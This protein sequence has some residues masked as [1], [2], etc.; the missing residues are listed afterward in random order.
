MAQ[1]PA[2]KSS[3]APTRVSSGS[4]SK[5]KGVAPKSAGKFDAENAT[6]R[7]VSRG[8]VSHPKN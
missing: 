1:K 5:P 2:Y 4:V 8:T 6:P 3:I 7:I